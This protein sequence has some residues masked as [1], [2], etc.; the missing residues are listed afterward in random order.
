MTLPRLYLDGRYGQIHARRIGSGAP[1][2][3]LH[4]SP[5]SSAQFEA[6][7]P[8][9]AASGLDCLALDMWGFGM[10]DP[11]PADPSLDDYASVIKA[12]LAYLGVERAHLVGHHTG[13]SVA[14]RFAA[15]APEA[16]D[17]LVLN[18]CALLS[19]EE[20][21]FFATFKFGPTQITPDGSHLTAAWQNRLKATP[22]WTDLN[23]MHR[24][25]IE[26]LARGETS[27]MAFPA[28]I[29]ADMAN[30]I[31][32]LKSPTLFFTNTGEDLYAATKRAH[33][34]RPDQAY[35][36]LQGG[37]HDIIDE[38]PEAWAKIVGDFLTGGRLGD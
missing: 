27:W 3:L 10:S 37:T 21:A 20:K 2:I 35:G 31:A 12:G 1:V 33:G 38:Q 8:S 26:G 23:A 29:G 19:A 15:R 6:A 13:A 36:E 7:M 5:L 14:A 16:V 4:Q 9:L 11:P 22:G 18:G 25:T 28:V 24:W 32:G 30:D 17:R 34:L